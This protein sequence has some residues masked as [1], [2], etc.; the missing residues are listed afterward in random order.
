MITSKEYLKDYNEMST[1]EKKDYIA[2]VEVW[3]EQTFPSLLAQAEC[4]M[5][6]PVKDFDEGC[7]LVSALVN[8]RP[9]LRDIQKYEVSRALKKMNLFLEKV[10]KA[11]G[12]ASKATRGPVGEK[13]YRA[14]VPDDGI[15]DENGELKQQTYQEPEVDNRRPQHL[16]QYKD[17][18]PKELR[19]RCE[20]EFKDMYLELAEFRGTLEAM[21]DNPNIPDKERS[22]M[23]NKVLASE[24]K[25]R[26]LWAEVDRA[27]GG[28]PMQE[29]EPSE[30][31]TPVMKR[32]GEFTREEI[33]AM[34]D[35]AQQE[36]CRKARIEGN[37]KYITRTD[38]KI[39][40]EYREQFMLRVN[41]LLLWG[42]KLPK[43]TAEVATAAGLSI[44]GVNAVSVD[45]TADN[46]T[47]NTVA[48]EKPADLTASVT[49]SALNDGK[50]GEA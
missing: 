27:M 48:T 45:N 36:I 34:T 26:S 25:I 49:E 2:R 20:K 13:R 41:E 33:E 29:E 24:Q 50:G 42:E 19:E 46:T 1:K 7:R 47:D 11:S 5:K 43:R 12:L 22:V 37:R 23:A 4:W 44:P 10:R 6:V 31:E 28:T 30:P 35:V 18:L 38:V 16:V 14:F 21:A 15:P 40:D 39:T 17:K 3:N 8:A 9:F 32:P